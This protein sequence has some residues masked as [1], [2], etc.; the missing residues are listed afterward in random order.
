MS[1]AGL[2]SRNPG[3]QALGFFLQLCMEMGEL[4]FQGFLLEVEDG[5]GV[6]TG[7]KGAPV[8]ETKGRE[9]RKAEW[10]KSLCGSHLRKGQGGSDLY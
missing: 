1:W 2:L 10:V 9:A 4:D 3:V 8:P 6:E 7:V 5:C